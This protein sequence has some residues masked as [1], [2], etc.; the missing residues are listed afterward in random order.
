MGANC[1]KPVSREMRLVKVKW[2]PL[3]DVSRARNHLKFLGG[4][5]AFIVVIDWIDVNNASHLF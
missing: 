1:W 4:W 3:A 5:S 2:M